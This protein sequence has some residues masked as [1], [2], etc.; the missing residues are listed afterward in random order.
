VSLIALKDL[1][2]TRGTSLFAGLNLS[3]AKGD[4][5]G[6]V[7]ANRRGKSSL[8]RIF[9]GTEEASTGSVTRAR[10]LVT[11]FARQDPPQHLLPLSLYEAVRS[12]LDGQVAEAESW[13]VDVLLDELAVDEV[14]R[15]R[16]VRSLS[17]GWQ[18]I[19][20]LARAAV[21]EPNL[22]AEPSLSGGVKRGNCAPSR[23]QIRRAVSTSAKMPSVDV[24]GTWM[25]LRHL[26]SRLW[27]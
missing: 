21:I 8:L 23:R 17:G 13:R 24:V 2:L 9:A 1:S 5:L 11:A 3:I 6:L 15:G 4:R 20:L 25:H 18:R 7:A 16:A 19:M 12:A 10:G 22:L 14:V 26:R 27:S